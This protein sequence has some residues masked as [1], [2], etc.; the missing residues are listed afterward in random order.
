M[1]SKKRVTDSQAYETTTE[2]GND[3]RKHSKFE[4]M[5]DN[6][7]SFQEASE[8]LNSESFLEHEEMTEDF[9]F[10]GIN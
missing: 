8:S 3:L 2:A 9:Q 7:S 1:D 5:S 10:S 4:G 6:Q